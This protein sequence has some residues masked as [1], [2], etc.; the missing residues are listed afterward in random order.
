[1]EDNF[2]F[3]CPYCNND[4]SINL[5]EDLNGIKCPECGNLIELDW[6]G[7]PD[8]IQDFGCIGKCSRCNGCKG[9][10]NL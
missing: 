6:S 5:N 4:I 8:E 1:M 9:R 7:N 3:T 10:S 2:E